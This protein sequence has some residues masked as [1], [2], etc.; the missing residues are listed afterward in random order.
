MNKFEKAAL[1]KAAFELV[2]YLPIVLTQ[3]YKLV[4]GSGNEERIINSL[5]RKI[6]K[7]NEEGVNAI[8][9]FQYFELLGDTNGLYSLKLK[10]NGFNLRFIC[11]RDKDCWVFLHCFSEKNDSD[12]DSYVKN[13][14]IAD[15]RRREWNERN[16]G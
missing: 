8:N 12:I 3:I 13:I 2:E 16:R 14:P 10:G 9:V 4:I 11:I 6:L 7:I 5:H 1:L 15:A